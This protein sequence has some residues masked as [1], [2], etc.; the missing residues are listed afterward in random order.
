VWVGRTREHLARAG[1]DPA[2]DGFAFMR[3]FS[4][5]IARVR[6]GPFDARDA[7]TGKLAA[8]LASARGPAGEPLLRVQVI[9]AVPRP[10]G[11]ERSLVE[12]ARQ[13]GTRLVARWVFGERFA[14]PAHAFVVARFDADA[15]QRLY[16]AGEVSFAGQ[17]MR[18]DALAFRESFDGEHHPQAIFLAAGGPIRAR[19]GRDRL[20]VLDVAPLLLYLAGQPIPDDL[21]GA[22]PRDWLQPAYLAAHPP[23]GVPAAQAP[24]LAPAAGAP[25][26]AVGDAEMQERLRS[27]GYLE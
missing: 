5:L 3:E 25:D 20:S 4:I 15:M 7:I 2:R 24:R 21:E 6:P 13:A 8:F 9:D 23:R 10:A 11:R 26:A 27:L 19:V 16:P 12:R 1:L 18:A 22:L 14:E 17:A